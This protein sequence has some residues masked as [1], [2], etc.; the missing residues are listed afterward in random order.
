MGTSKKTSSPFFASVTGL[1]SLS[2]ILTP[3]GVPGAVVSLAIWALVETVIGP[4]RSPALPATE[5]GESEREAFGSSSLTA[6]FR[7]CSV[8][9]RASALFGVAVTPSD[10]VQMAAWVAAA[11]SFFDRSTSSFLPSSSAECFG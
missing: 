6:S 2:T 1:P 8:S 5:D 9:L 4:S 7:S 3:S 11:A 10:R